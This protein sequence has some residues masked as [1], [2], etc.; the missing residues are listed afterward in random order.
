MSDLRGKGNCW[1]NR[2]ITF[3]M[4]NF[5]DSNTDQDQ[6]TDS[7]NIYGSCIPVAAKSHDSFNVGE[8]RGVTFT[9]YFEPSKLFF[10]CHEC[11]GMRE[12]LFVTTFVCCLLRS[13]KIVIIVAFIAM[14]PF[15]RVAIF[16]V[17]LRLS[18]SGKST[19]P[20]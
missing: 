11:F 9:L 12:H 1:N 18:V 16:K 14:K 19:R 8:L 20:K 10:E 5:I 2:T 3:P 15:R 4:R 17:F 7:W 6:L 13:H